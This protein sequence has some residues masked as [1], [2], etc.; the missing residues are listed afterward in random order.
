MAWVD[1]LVVPSHLATAQ[2]LSL[3]DVVNGDVVFLIELS[4]CGNKTTLQNNT[5]QGNV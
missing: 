1:P 4:C 5:L 3:G 2:E